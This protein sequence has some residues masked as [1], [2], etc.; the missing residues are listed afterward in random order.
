MPVT[1]QTAHALYGDTV[2]WTTSEHLLANVVDLTSTA[3]WQRGGGKGKRPKR[4][5]R[6]GKDKPTRHGSTTRSPRETARFLARFAPQE[7]ND[8]GR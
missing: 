4:L 7:V 6:P 5:H 3:N 1:S 8:D 2:T